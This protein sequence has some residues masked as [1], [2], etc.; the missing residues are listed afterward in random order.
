MTLFSRKTELRLSSIVAAGHPPIIH[1]IALK[2]GWTGIQSGEVLLISA[3]G[4]DAWDGTAASG[5]V[6]GLSVDIGSANVVGSA[7]TGD[8]ALSA[9]ANTGEGTV[10]GNADTTTG[11]ITATADTG[12]GA[13]TG[14]ANTGDGAITAT[15]DFG[16]KSV[17]GSASTTPALMGIAVSTPLEGDASVLVL[18]HGCYRAEAVTVG[19]QALT[20][21]HVLTLMAAGLYPEDSWGS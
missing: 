12:D 17:T 5:S 14:S 10:T 19:A 13:V 1:A 3:D 16:T 15:V 18:L 20:H 11:V 2:E 9:T 4:A 7:N 6:T 8:G 21:A